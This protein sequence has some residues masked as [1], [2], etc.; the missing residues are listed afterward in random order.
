MKVY[1]EKQNKTINI[2]FNGTVKML[3]TKLKLNIETVLVVK[4]NELVS[5]DEGLKDSDMVSVLS[6]ISGG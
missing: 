4:N 1:I 6:V 2:K 5:E 3:I